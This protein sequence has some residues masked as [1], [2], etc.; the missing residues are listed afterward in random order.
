[1]EGVDDEYD[2][3]SPDDDVAANEKSASRYDLD[4]MVGKVIV[5]RVLTVNDRVTS[6]AAL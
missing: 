2:T 3:V 4:G 6:G 5:W 1:M